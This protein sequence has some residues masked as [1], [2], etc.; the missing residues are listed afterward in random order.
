MLSGEQGS[1]KSTFSALLRSLLDPNTAPLRALPR[2][3]RDRSSQYRDEYLELRDSYVPAHQ[4]SRRTKQFGSKDACLFSEVDIVIVDEFSMVGSFLFHAVE[5]YAKEVDLPMVYSGDRFQLPPVKDREVI[6]DQ[7]FQ[8][9]T[10][11]R[12]MRF[13]ESSEIFRFG[14][15]LRDMIAH[16]PD[17]EIPMLYSG[18]EVQVMHGDN[19]MGNLTL[20]IPRTPAVSR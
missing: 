5:E 4:A 20:A 9:I 15:M 16:D 6:M 2:E 3:D 10:L 14:E 8:T 11:N 13:P 17:G 19:W 12:S 7:N 1:A 18:P